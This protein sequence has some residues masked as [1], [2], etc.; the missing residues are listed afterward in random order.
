WRRRWISWRGLAVG[1]LLTLPVLFWLAWDE[2][3]VRAPLTMEE[4]SP[5]FAGDE[6][7]YAVLMQYSKGQPSAA[8]KAFAADKLRANAYVGAT[9]KDAAKWREA[10]LKRQ[11]EIEATWTA[12]EP[13]RQWLTELNAFDRIGDLTPAKYDANIMGFGVWRVLSQ[14]ACATATL[15][16]LDGRGGDAMDVLLPVLEVSRKLQPSARTLVR[17]MIAVST[18]RSLVET[19]AMVLDLTEVPQRERDRLTALLQPGL[20][21]GGARR[22]MLMEYVFF[23]PLINSLK[24]GDALA[25]FRGSPKLVVR[26]SLNF[27]S[28]LFINPNATVNRY[29]D[30]IYTLADLARARKLEQLSAQTKVFEKSLEHDGGIKNF[31]GRLM[32]ATS[33]PS[34]DKILESYWTLQDERAATLAK[35]KS[36]PV[37]VD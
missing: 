26:R 12:L 10:V 17:A 18:E 31:G 19:A 24:L 3:T 34:Y 36:K 29:G 32:L 27:L 2:P 25:L 15:L 33:L 5:R 6:Q 35:L 23:Q 37:P 20:E 28:G 8:A 9:T 1:W 16:A 4:L 7:S 13:E 30:Q 22:L 14:H 11:A 21:A